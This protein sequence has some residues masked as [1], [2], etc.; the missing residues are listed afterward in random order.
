[1]IRILIVDDEPSAGNVL[2]VLIEKNIAGQ[3]EI[4]VC[5]SAMDALE[6]IPLF[7]PGL[8]MLDIEM[9]HMNGFDLLNR[10]GYS[11]CDVI[12]TT[13]Y[14]KYAIKA[15]RFSALDYLLK[16]IDIV[17]LQNAINRHII[18]KQWLP[19]QQREL[20]N[21]LISNLQQQDTSSFKLALST[22]EGV[23][24]F[25]P[26]Q[27]LRCEGDNNYTHFYFTDRSPLIV[28]KTLKEYE[29]ILA[30]HGFMRVHKSH[31]V[32][33]VY[34]ARLDRENV[35][36]MSDGSHIGVSRRRKEDVLQMLSRKK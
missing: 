18:R 22:M 20:V 26:E 14:D 7:R 34:V 19:D 13:A 4:R 30:D 33:I 6:L 31:L 27:I 25:A 3:K 24:F 2:K 5:S 23:Y 16:P 28:S 9:P 21:N 8:L 11:D 32:N 15:I 29:E 10:A 1:M 12:F 36:W 35:L 17:E